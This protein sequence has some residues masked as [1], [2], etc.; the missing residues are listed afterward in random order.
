MNL[1]GLAPTEFQSLLVSVG[2]HLKQRPLTPIEVGELFARMMRNGATVH[3]CAAA[4]HF[5]GPSMV[6]R[7]LSLLTLTP[8]I[9]HNVDWGTSGATIGFSAAVE[10]ARLEPADQ[11]IL[12][13][14]AMEH[15]FSSAELKQ[16]LQLR[17][18]SGRD[19]QSCV[20]EVLGLR[21]SVERRHLFIGAITTPVLREELAHLHQRERDAR[22]ARALRGV[23]PRDATIGARLG[24]DTFTIVT[25][26]AGAAVL[27]RLTPNF[28]S[29]FNAKLVEQP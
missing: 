22:L 4:V 29:V 9:R 21:P 1:F 12:A 5:D 20:E 23:L 11:E 14:A 15:S 24:A 13:R 10:I 26:D 18:R 2:S 16:I 27:R 25:T 8:S 6:R 7:F 3:E 19:V 17:K 28:E